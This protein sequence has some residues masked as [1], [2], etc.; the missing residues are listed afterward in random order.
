MIK[1][2][3]DRFEDDLV[4][5]EIEGENKVVKRSNIP[6][7]AREGDVMVFSH[8]NWTIDKVSTRQR[9]SNIDKLANELWSE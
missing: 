4:I 2:I 3:I 5:I 1:G 6:L 8:N 9:K 7:E